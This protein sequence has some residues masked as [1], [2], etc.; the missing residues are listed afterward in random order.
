M[1]KNDEISTDSH[2][3]CYTPIVDNWRH[4]NVGRLLNTSLRRFETRV[5]ELMATAGHGHFAPSHINATRHLDVQGTRLT[6]LA[7]RAA[8][9]KQ[10]MSELVGQLEKLGIVARR[11]D[12]TDARARIIYFTPHGIRWLEAFHQALTQ[13]ENEMADLIGT[14]ALNAMKC[15]LQTYHAGYDGGLTPP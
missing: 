15:S 3:P 8:M 5:L 6:E 1:K 9:T 4:H 2:A 14:D 11:V 10:S 12:P 7:Q 13:A